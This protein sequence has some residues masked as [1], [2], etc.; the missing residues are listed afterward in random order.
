MILLGTCKPKAK[1]KPVGCVIIPKHSG[2]HVVY[3]FSIGVNHYSY[4]DEYTGLPEYLETVSD[5]Y[6][7]RSH[8]LNAGY[9]LDWGVFQKLLQP[10]LWVDTSL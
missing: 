8:L 1:F 3:P 9:K 7:L 5:L 10:H 6:T 2:Y 4:T